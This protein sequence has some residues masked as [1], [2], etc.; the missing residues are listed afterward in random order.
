MQRSLVKSA[1][2]GATLVLTVAGVQAAENIVEQRQQ[3]FKKMGGAMKAINQQLK[4]SDADLAEILASASLLS[5]KAAQLPD[6]F[7]AGSGASS[8]QQTDALDAIWQDSATF[9]QAATKFQ[10]A[11]SDLLSLAQN[12]DVAALPAQ[13]KE[14]KQSCSNCHKTF[15]AD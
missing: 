15:R 13:L 3:S 2:W 14:V 11:S 9:Q 7:P 4:A 10:Q 12:G 1:L 8:G 5:S 6:W